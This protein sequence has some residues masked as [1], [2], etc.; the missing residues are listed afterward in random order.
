MKQLLTFF[1]F[2]IIHSIG[3]CQGNTYAVV[4]GIA[5]YSNSDIPQLQ[6]ANKDAVVFADFLKSKAGGTVP[7]E[8]IQLLVDSEATTAA[9]YDAIYWI[10]KT[11]QKNDLVYFYFSGHGDLENVTMYKDGFLICYNS[12]STNYVKMAV[13][14]EYLNKIA[15][16]L[17]SQTKANVVLITDACHS[18]KLAGDKNRGNQLVGEQLRAVKNKEIR[19]T[20]CAENELSNENEEW[21]GGRGVFSYY[22]INGLKGLAD[23][24]K[25]GVVTLD[26]IK[27]Y[28]N[29]AFKKDAVLKREKLTQTPVL[30]GKPGFALATIDN[31]EMKVAEKQIAE[32]LVVQMSIAPAPQEADNGPRQPQEL[33]FYLL[34][35]KS[36]EE[37]TDSLKLADLAATEISFAIIKE[38]SKGLTNDGQQK[39]LAELQN[40]LTENKEALK[41]FN[42]RLAVAFDDAGQKVIDQYLKGDEAE[43][44]RRR[45]YNSNNNGYD[46]YPKMFAIALKLTQPDNFLYSILEVKLH[47]FSGVNLRLKIPTV[48][49][50][51]PLIKKALAE[52]KKALALEKNAAYI[53]NELGVLYSLKKES[54]F[55]EKYFKKASELS[56]DWVIPW[57]NLS[58]LYA[59]IRSFAK[60]IEASEKAKAINADL[61]CI[62]LNSGFL[63]EKK[64]DQLLAEEHY[65][66]A[67]HINSRHYSPFERLGYVYMNTTQYALANSFFYEADIRKRGYHFPPG[68][69]VSDQQDLTPTIP[70]R[71]ICEVYSNDVGP[72]DVMGNC[73]LGLNATESFG[74]LTADGVRAYERS[75]GMIPPKDMEIG[76]RTFKKAIELDK[77]NPLAFH[78][79]GKL[80][81]WQKRFAEAD[82]IFNLALKF[83]LDHNAFKQYVDS[84]SQLLPNTPSKKCIITTFRNFEYAPIED[85]Y[86]LASIYEQWHHYTEAEMEYRKIIAT[87]SVF[88]GGYFKLWTFL[89]SIGRYKDAEDVIRSFVTHNPGKKKEGENELNAF[90]NRVLAIYPNDAEW[91]YKR[92]LFLYRLAADYPDDY[93]FDKKTVTPDTYEEEFSI[94]PE[95]NNEFYP[96]IPGPWKDDS[97]PAAEEIYFPR[98]EAIACLLIAD[99]LSVFPDETVADINDKLGDL[100]NWQGLTERAIPYYIK[101]FELQPGNAGVRMKLIDDYDVGFHFQDA[102]V[103]LDSLNQRNEI[104]FSKMLLMA[105]YRIH[106]G[107]FADAKQLLDSAEK[108]HP[109]KMP[110]VIDLNGR[111]Q[112]M[113]GREN[114]AIQ[115]YE[116]LYSVNENDNGI[117]YTL[118]RLYA[119]EGKTAEAWKWLDASA[120]K[121]F[122][123]LYVLLSDNYLE[124][125]RKTTKWSTYLKRINKMHPR[126]PSVSN[127]FSEGGY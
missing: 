49:N 14:V 74:S 94:M 83:H 30:N 10:S 88:I 56:P 72:A 96:S 93:P 64:G 78:Y 41:R 119:K 58:G 108:I 65:H 68:E 117:C 42:G 35:K 124:K 122:N 25:D 5:S 3:L 101:S 22:L 87:D 107:N 63:Y 61:L 75:H 99:S 57:A 23:K 113:S 6:F 89:E 120:D 13:S 55:A 116:K 104:N 90:Y 98:N 54:A 127:R 114:D 44:E 31:D 102:L 110:E 70:E 7:A 82:I 47:Y 92:G 12:P 37:M 60:G 80:L 29:D 4:V 105:K 115:L 121:G 66:K 48:K 52:Q 20:S 103:Q 69:G 97:Y 17:S 21:G 118:A 62:Y 40:K 32:D 111:L 24:Q 79:L 91:N 53:Y 95:S 85:H 123:Y 100:Y 67:I 39:K 76:E 50:P 28:L 36:L 84:L 125:I 109:Y 106:S 112:L 77:S 9:V 126:Q 33:F 46:V 19:I 73:A 43:L 11:A 15:N 51:A 71:E 18:G 34:K 27:S 59:D 45:Y 81:Y 1:L 86:F 16:T 2:M 8:N 38:L 26:E